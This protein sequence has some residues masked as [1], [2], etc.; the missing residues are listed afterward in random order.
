MSMCVLKSPSDRRR[1]KNEQG[2]VAILFALV[3]T[4]MF[5]LFAFVVDFGH[6]INNK[7]NLQIAADSAAYAGAAWQARILNQMG[8]VNYHI[9]Q[10]LKELAMRLHVTH[11]RHNRNFPRGSQFVN[12]GDDL[13]RGFYPFVCQQAHGYVANSGLRYA[14]DTNLCRNASP[15]FGGL[16]PIVVPP[17]IASFDPFAVAIAA[18]IRQ[19]Q[20]KANQECRAAANDNRRLVEY[21]KQIYEARSRFHVNQMRE[22]ENYLNQVSNETG[23]LGR[24]NPGKSP[25]SQ[26][27]VQSA[28]RNLSFSNRNEFKLEIMQ[29][30]TGEYVRLLDNITNASFFFYDFSVVGNGCVGKPAK[31]DGVAVSTGMTKN[32][33]IITYFAVKASSK[34]SMLFMP[35]AWVEAA[36]PELQAFA[37][38]KPFGSRIGPQ[39]TADQL[40]PV[41]NRPGNNNPMINFSF[42][43]QD[44]YGIMNTKIMA[45]LDSLHPYNS[46]G[47]PDGNQ[48]AGWP[49]PTKP[50]PIRQPLQAIRAP[51]VFDALF[52][53]VFPDPGNN[54]NDDY[55]ETQY[56]EVLYPDYLEAADPDNNLINLPTPRTPAFLPGGVGSRNK[57]QGWIQINADIQNPGGPYG[58]INYAQEEKA[59]HSVTGMSSFQT[60]KGKEISF[61]FANKDLMQSAW[62][63]DGRPGRIGYSVKFIGMD[64]LMRTLE[65]T[66]DQS[67]QRGRIANPPTGD[68]NLNNI[69]H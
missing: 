1:K 31:L 58:D 43:P 9:R 50:P 62:T 36:F 47:R 66:L 54:I 19:I 14:S 56:A 3:F 23:N 67:G 41:P 38:A 21:L 40:V 28:L 57:G 46:V 18:Q 61:G 63:P 35:Q 6:L 59:S 16:P 27:A 4:F 52:Y 22:L 55:L 11:V 26:S 44:R 65:V 5:I 32:P 33:A 39:T 51:T 34:P 12:G 42:R 49:D 13:P 64:A 7:I 17:V 20:Q 29:P 10:D 45:F 24:E 15:E 68:P 69:Y 8:Q 53:T 2:Q 30:Q 25:I 37:A 60:V 48:T